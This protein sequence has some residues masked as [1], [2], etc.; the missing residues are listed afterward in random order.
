MGVDSSCNLGGGDQILAMAAVGVDVSLG[1]Q[2]IVNTNAKIDHDTRLGDGVHVMPGATVA[3]QVV[4]EDEVVIGT[5]AT[6]LPNLK[7]GSYV[8]RCAAP[9]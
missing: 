8:N 3:G 4:I 2:C 1:R 6:I 9:T 7:T 5:N